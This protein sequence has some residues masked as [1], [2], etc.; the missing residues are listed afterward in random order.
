[1]VPPKKKVAPKPVVTKLPMERLLVMCDYNAKGHIVFC[2][3]ATI[4]PEAR[5]ETALAFHGIF[6]PDTAKA[7]A[8][9]VYD[10]EP[11]QTG[12]SEAPDNVATISFAGGTWR[13]P[14]VAEMVAFHTGQFIGIWKDIGHG[15]QYD[16]MHAQDIEEMEQ[17][18]AADQEAKMRWDALAAPTLKRVKP[19]PE[20][21]E[22]GE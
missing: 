2:Q 5:E 19:E 13:K 12:T 14:G 3:G 16:L 15:E 20:P 4:E 10:V 9:L 17:R 8:I 7:G 22:V 6:L 11:E 21:E 18:I 1:M